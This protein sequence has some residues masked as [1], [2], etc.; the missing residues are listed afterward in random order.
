MPQKC[1]GFISNHDV[2]DQKDADSS[3]ELTIV[4]DTLLGLLCATKPIP[5][6]Q[7]SALWAHHKVGLHL[8]SELGL[9]M[10]LPLSGS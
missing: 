7:S 10:W 3:S 1:L 6:S 8:I 9:A 2:Q 5:V 4:I